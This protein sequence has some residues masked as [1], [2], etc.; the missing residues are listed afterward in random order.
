MAAV[1]QQVSIGRQSITLTQGFTLVELMLVVAII[2]ILA[3]IALPAYQDY[4]N[5]A[6]IAEALTIIRPLQNQIVK[7]FEHTGDFPTGAEDLGYGNLDGFGGQY[8][9]KIVMG[10]GFIEAVVNV[11][12]GSYR[13]W[14]NAAVPDKQMPVVSVSWFCMAEKA[15][16]G[17]KFIGNYVAIHKDIEVMPPGF[18]DSHCRDQR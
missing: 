1:A 5:R 12:G 17:F 4:V 16:E 11:G 8:V 18:L 6:K 7:H 2:G 10:E 13:I 15:A 3:A 9:Q 14:L